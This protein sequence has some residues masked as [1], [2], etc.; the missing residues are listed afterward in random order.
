MNII[1]KRFTWRRVDRAQARS[2][3]FMSPIGRA[4]RWH[5]TRDTSARLFKIDHLGFS[6]T[7]CSIAL[8]D[9]GHLAASLGVPERGISAMAVPVGNQTRTYR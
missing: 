4:A 6:V 9:A 7:A 2:I 8:E 3:G 1:M 5:A